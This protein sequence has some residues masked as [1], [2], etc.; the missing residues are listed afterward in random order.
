MAIRSA[1][2]LIQ[3][4]HSVSLCYDEE[5]FD[6]A[7]EYRQMGGHYSYHIGTTLKTWT[8][9]WDMLSE[10]AKSAKWLLL[11]L[12][13]C[14]TH[15][16]IQ[17]NLP[18][19]NALVRPAQIQRSVFSVTPYSIHTAVSTLVLDARQDDIMSLFPVLMRF[20]WERLTRL[21]I[22][23]DKYLPHQDA[24]SALDNFTTFFSSRSYIWGIEA[25]HRDQSLLTHVDQAFIN[26]FVSF[27]ERDRAHVVT[28]VAKPL[29]SHLESLLCQSIRVASLAWLVCEY[30]YPPAPA[31]Q[32]KA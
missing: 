20:K 2:A 27:M 22:W 11:D 8:L 28:I 10:R 5:V 21:V 16:E 1:A 9:L 24:E 13:A 25:V 29:R 26:N 7:K 23:F 30:L 14:R 12:D 19:Q 31:I 17:W 32:A 3:A 18:T 6:V 15:H 4:A